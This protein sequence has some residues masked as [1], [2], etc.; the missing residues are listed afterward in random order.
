MQT[1][2][3]IHEY[4]PSSSPASPTLL[5][6][7][8]TGGDESSLLSLGQ[9]LAPEAA[10]LSPRGKVLEGSAPRFFRRKAEGVFDIE[11]LIFR[12]H[13]LADWLAVASVEY[14]IA[15]GSVIALGYSNGANIAASIL[16]LRPDAFKRAVLLRAMVPLVP[17]QAPDLSEAAVL[18]GSGTVDSL[19]PLPQSE[20]LAQMLRDYGADVTFHKQP[21]D[22]RLTN[23]DLVSVRQWLDQEQAKNKRVQP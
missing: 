4:V 20:K 19:I 15:P 16:L 8:G 3:F 1:N 6:L 17:E 12:T 23:G 7:H 9:Q 14:G 22:H 11:D 10:L 5:L 2:E 21:A 18:M 13:E